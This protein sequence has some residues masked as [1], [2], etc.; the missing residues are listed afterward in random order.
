MMKS[1]FHAGLLSILELSP[2]YCVFLCFKILAVQAK[3]ILHYS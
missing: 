3:F 2:V 1:V